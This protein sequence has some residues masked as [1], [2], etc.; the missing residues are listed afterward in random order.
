MNQGQSNTERPEQ[1]RNVDGSPPKEVITIPSSKLSHTSSI[2]I[3]EYGMKAA[4]EGNAATFSWVV[5]FKL[6]KNVK[7]LQG[8]DASLDFSINET[9]ICGFMRIQCGVSES[10]AYQWWEEH[11]TTLRSHLTESRNNKI[12]MIKQNFSGKYG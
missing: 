11:K 7:F 6:F 1:E 9:T 10:D 5:K 3:G 12:K 2:G 8:P 4:K